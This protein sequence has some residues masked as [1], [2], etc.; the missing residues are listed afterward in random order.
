MEIKYNYLI[1]TILI[2]SIL[3]F[4]LSF[5][6]QFG[7]LFEGTPKNYKDLLKIVSCVLGVIVGFPL[8]ITLLTQPYWNSITFEKENNARFKVS[9]NY[10]DINLETNKIYEF[11]SLKITFKRFLGIGFIFFKGYGYKSIK[12]NKICVPFIRQ[13]SIA[14]QE[15]RQTLRNQNLTSIE[16][17]YFKFKEKV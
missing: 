9:F 3:I 11:N 6:F 15:L 4:S 12:S 5:L 14:Q 7:I 8:V 1:I 16:V 17:N 2:L 13:I 10:F